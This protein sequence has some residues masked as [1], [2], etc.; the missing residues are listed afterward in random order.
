M[1]DI[2]FTYS[3]LYS[4]K[5]KWEKPSVMMAFIYIDKLFIDL[6]WLTLFKYSADLYTKISSQ[7]DP[8]VSDSMAHSPVLMWSHYI[9]TIHN[10]YINNS[11]RLHLSWH[12][13]TSVGKKAQNN[14]L[15]SAVFVCVCCACIVIQIYN[16]MFLVKSTLIEYILLWWNTLNP[17]Q[18]LTIWARLKPKCISIPSVSLPYNFLSPFILTPY[19]FQRLFESINKWLDERDPIF[20][21]KSK[22][23]LSV[24]YGI[25]Q[26]L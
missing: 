4:R 21:I 3:W 7:Y 19:I 24:E 10:S 25:L 11:K 26:S 8:W 5:E 1:I 14:Y 13:C 22:I 6:P 15:C 16:K 17:S 12:T 18:T 2:V 23:N 20:S 9:N